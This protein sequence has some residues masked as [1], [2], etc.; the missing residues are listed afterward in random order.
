[1]GRRAVDPTHRIPDGCQSRRARIK[2]QDREVG[3]GSD[4]STVYI[5]IDVSKEHVDVASEDGAFESRFTNDDEGHGQLAARLREMSPKLV[6]ME[7]TGNFQLE[8]SLAVL[9]AK[10][11]VAVVNPRQV[12]DFA[13]ALGILA[14]TDAIDARTIARFG[15]TVKPDAQPLPDA[16]TLELEALMTRR[17]QLVAM[18]ASEKNRR[19]ALFGPAKKSWAEKSINDTI[20]HLQKQLNQLDK[21]L[22]KRLKNSE[23]WKEKHDLLKS[24]PGV[25]D[26]TSFTLVIDLPELGSLNRK[27]IAALA[28]L[29]PIN[30]D[31]GQFIGK[32]RIWGGRACV[33]TALYMACV[34]S[35]RC[36]PVIQ[37]VYDRLK[38]QARKPTK[39]ALV[40]CMRK[41]LTILNAMVRDRREWTTPPAAAAA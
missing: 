16:Q 37:A 21:D 7:A 40:A 38:N 13:K 3:A 22:K 10:V 32:R 35:L 27:Q 30:R 4:G 25:G 18:L 11:P 12:R 29:A 28:G 39:V 23:V 2:P 14:K 41:L 36:N 20:S 34:A 33:R 8:L 5:G 19:Q 6:V 24:V 15:A 26:V 17:R 9:G 1:M 31:S